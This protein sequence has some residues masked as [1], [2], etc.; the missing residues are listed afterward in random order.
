MTDIT[1]QTLAA[2]DE[3]PYPFVDEEYLSAAGKRQ[4]LADWQRFSASGFKKL[5]FTRELYRFLHHNCGFTAHASQDGY[6]AYY[7]N[8]ELIR[9][10][11]W[12]NQFG[13]SRRSVEFNTHAWLGGPAAD[14]KLAMCQELTRLY[15]PLS[16]VLEDLAVKHAELG[17]AWREFALSSGLP[18]P[19]YPPHYLV[20]ENARNLLAY[21]ATIARRKP[22]PLAGLQRQFPLAGLAEPGLYVARAA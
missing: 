21:A 11:A 12:L 20:S 13:G 22:Q 2:D 16:Q 10:Q 9:L 3:E 5:F 14:L 18:D 7:F 19:G 8:A 6:W 15:A 4:I 1:I 17:R